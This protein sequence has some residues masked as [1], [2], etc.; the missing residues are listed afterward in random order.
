VGDTDVR[1]TGQRSIT[2]GRVE[3]P[4]MLKKQGSRQERWMWCP[5]LQF[6]ERRILEGG[7]VL[8]QF[9]K[10]ASRR[11]V[12]QRERRIVRLCKSPEK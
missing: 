5:H 2:G 7:V 12:G 11:I 6:V 3:H 4:A 1:Q 9:L 8:K 10:N